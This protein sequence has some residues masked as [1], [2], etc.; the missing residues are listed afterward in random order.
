MGRMTTRNRT[1]APTTARARLAS[2]LRRLSSVADDYT[3]HAFNP[4]REL[5]GRR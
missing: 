2:T 3:L 4:Q 1:H 5:R